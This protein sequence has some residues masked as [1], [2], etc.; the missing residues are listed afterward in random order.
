MYRSIEAMRA[1][2]CAQRA[3]STSLVRAALDRAL[4]RDGEGA[5]TFTQLFPDDAM[6]AATEADRRGAARNPRSAIDGLPVSIKDLF[7]VA[8]M[9][10]MAGA[11]ALQ[12]EAQAARDATLV[13]RLRQTGAAIVGKTNM[14]QFALSGLGLNPD[15]GTPRAPWR[16]EEGRIAGGSSSGAA[17]SVADHMA[18]AAIG[19]DTGG[20]V[21]IP[22]AF[23]GLVGFKPTAA[24]IDRTGTVALSPSLDSLG[25]LA[26]TVACCATMDRLLA[27]A[28]GAAVPALRD[29]IRLGI[30]ESYVWDESD[31]AV[32]A[33]FEKVQ[34]R[35]SAHGVVLVTL[36]MA[37]LERIRAISELGGISPIEGWQ[38]NRDVLQRHRDRIDP[39]VINRFLAARDAP[40]DALEAMYRI[41]RE[42]IE[43]AAIETATYDAIL[44]PTVAIV[45][46]READ[47]V[48][49]DAYALAN[50][51][52]IRNAQVANLL[53]RCA[54]TIPCSAPGE[55]PVGMTLMG[56]TGGDAALLELAEKLEPVIRSEADR[57]VA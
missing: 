48:D 11:M 44:M 55:P 38:A 41:R 35:L 33:A 18:I 19:S 2:R 40:P 28:P 46:P 5:R 42:L 32:L 7:D 8:G 30:P 21:R 57:A 56:P 12:S 13:A 14:T 50:R 24:R 26:H 17:I 4:D 36:R 34:R 49:D 43:A 6:Q 39:R 51:L 16:R 45:P 53:D 23:C 9:P 52:V 37:M 25:F 3:T 1:G 47:L 27:D 29:Q 22:A 10:T 54:I 20:S 15:Y 31:P